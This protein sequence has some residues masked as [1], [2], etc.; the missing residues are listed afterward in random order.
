MLFCALV[1]LRR[2]FSNFAI[3]PFRFGVP[4]IWATCILSDKE[5]FFSSSFARCLCLDIRLVQLFPLVSPISDNLFMAFHSSDFFV[6]CFFFHSHSSNA[7]VRR[8]FLNSHCVLS[9]LLFPSDCLQYLCI[10]C[11]FHFL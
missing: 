5:V 9:T 3:Y 8:S 4:F 2:F 1:F 7:R 6:L 10:A 11:N